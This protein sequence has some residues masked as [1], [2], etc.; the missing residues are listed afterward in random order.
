[1]K[2]QTQLR[3]AGA[4][5]TLYAA[6]NSRDLLAAWFHSPFDRMGLPAFVVWLLPLLIMEMIRQLPEA[7]V[8]KFFDAGFFLGLGFSLAGV[9][10]NLNFLK[11]LGLAFSCAGF[12]PLRPALAVWFFSCLA[13]MPVLGWAFSPA[14]T[15]AV[16]FFRVLLAA[17]GAVWMSL[18]LANHE[19]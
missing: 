13:W 3:I 15:F 7:R 2:N 19:N 12:L 9:A 11:H 10:L 4:A 6:W 17:G 8:G 14:G 16:N 5:I 1:M 18:R